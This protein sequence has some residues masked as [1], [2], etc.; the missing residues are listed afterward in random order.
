M[1]LKTSGTERANQL[2]KSVPLKV[3]LDGDYND[4]DNDKAY[5][6]EIVMMM[7]MMDMTAVIKT[8]IMI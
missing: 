5:N 4:D 1:E 3:I 8:I 7:M 2:C 6:D